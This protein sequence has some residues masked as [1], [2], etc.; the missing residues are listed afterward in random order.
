MGSR[1]NISISQTI[2]TYL[3]D[4]KIEGQINFESDFIDEPDLKE[5]DITIEPLC[6]FARENI[7]ECYDR[8]EKAVIKILDNIDFEEE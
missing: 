4:F 8:C 1:Y 2:E 3:G 7:E 6:S 5:Y